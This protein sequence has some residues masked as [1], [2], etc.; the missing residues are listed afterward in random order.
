MAA[1]LEPRDDAALVQASLSGDRL[2]FRALYERYFEDVARSAAAIVGR[3]SEVED[4][5]QESFLMIH[6]ALG[7]FD[8]TR[9]FGAWAGTIARN[10]A[11]SRVRKRRPTIDLQTIQELRSPKEAWAALDAR[12]QVRALYAALET[13]EDANRESFI[14]AEIEGRT[15]REVAEMRG[16]SLNTVASRVRRVRQKLIAMM[17]AAATNQ[18]TEQVP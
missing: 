4:V 7:Q 11:S 14:L 9:S 16:E 10:T 2:A 17:Q 1:E 12:D 6:Q 18:T 13:F 8:P 15:L 5:V 3:G